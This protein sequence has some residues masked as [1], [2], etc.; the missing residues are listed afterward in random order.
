M[1]YHRP[2]YLIVKLLSEDLQ[3]LERG[4]TTGT[5]VALVYEQ[6]NVEQN[7]LLG[8]RFDFEQ[9]APD[10]FISL[11]TVPSSLVGFSFDFKQFA[12]C[13]FACLFRLDF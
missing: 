4:K 2:K 7:F 8:F 3:A 13:G 10:N 9:S 5:V 12:L 11:F 1:N 6:S